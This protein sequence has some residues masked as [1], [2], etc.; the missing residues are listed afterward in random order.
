M[1]DDLGVC[2]GRKGLTICVVLRNLIIDWR[3]P[4]GPGNCRGFFSV[5][6][7]QAPRS[8]PRAPVAQLAAQPICNR[9]VRGSSPLWGSKM[10][11]SRL[12]HPSGS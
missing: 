9:Q 10:I 11:S 4:E 8:Q 1:W 2:N 12:D 3:K 5:L 6:A 7:G